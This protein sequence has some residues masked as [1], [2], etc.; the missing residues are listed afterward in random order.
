MCP[1]IKVFMQYRQ[2]SSRL[3]ALTVT[4]CWVPSQC[5]CLVC[6][7]SSFICN[8]RQRSGR[9]QRAASGR[10]LLQLLCLPLKV[11]KLSVI[12]AQR[13]SGTVWAGWVLSQSVR[14]CQGEKQTEEREGEVETEWFI[15]LAKRGRKRGW[16]EGGGQ[17]TD[18]QDKLWDTLTLWHTDRRRAGSSVPGKNDA[19]WFV[20]RI[21]WR[22][23][24]LMTS[25]LLW[26]WRGQKHRTDLWQS[27]GNLPWGHLSNGP[28]RGYAISPFFALCSSWWLRTSSEKKET[29]LC[30]WFIWVSNLWGAAWLGDGAGGGEDTPAWISVPWEG[31]F[32]HEVT[33]KITTSRQGRE[34][35]WPCAALLS[36]R[37]TCVGKK[38]LCKWP[39]PSRTVLRFTL[40]SWWVH[41]SRK[42]FH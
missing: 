18:P 24:K 5:C 12:P 9:S 19:W 32:Q 27:G 20:V 30:D 8:S 42:P 39:E 3:W 13:R 41:C 21:L 34:P 23:G 22:G 6:V 17:E 35:C 37:D 25:L 14:G 2:Y 10:S 1:R 11:Q 33:P 28:E 38:P 31:S 26:S 29:R 40:H 4:L 15:Q 36:N 7:D 16:C